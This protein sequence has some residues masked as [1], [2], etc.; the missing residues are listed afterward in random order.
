LAGARFDS[1][2]FAADCKANT[3]P[4]ACKLS[5]ELG[6]DSVGEARKK[7]EGDLR[8]PR[9]GAVVSLD[10]GLA[11]GFTPESLAAV[12]TPTLIVGAGIDIGGLPADLE[13]G[14]LAAGLPIST[15]EYVVV[16]DAMHFSFLQLCKPGAVGMI[17]ERS[18]G[19]GVACKDSPARSRAS[20]HRE[21][22]DRIT[23]FLG[24]ILP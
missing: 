10:L 13:S 18:P 6:L 1:E 24:T 3:S 20:I 16:P 8:D 2:R 19:D 22:A 11:R 17:E 5:H 4:R 15:R 23:T 7:L 12:S 9:I 21:V 14:Y